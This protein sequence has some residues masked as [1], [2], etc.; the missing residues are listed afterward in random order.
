MLLD[1]DGKGKGKCTAVRDE[2]PLIGKCVRWMNHV[3]NGS[4]TLTCPEVCRVRHWLTHAASGSRLRRNPTI[5]SSQAQVGL[6]P[7]VPSTWLKRSLTE[8]LPFLAV[9]CEAED[10]A[11]RSNLEKDTCQL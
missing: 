1:P 10:S 2:R 3:G 8:C 7:N 4:A 11:D 6:S 5:P 9:L